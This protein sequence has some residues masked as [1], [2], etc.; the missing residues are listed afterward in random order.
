MEGAESLI[1]IGIF[2]AVVV[3]IA[4]ICGI[5]DADRVWDSS[6]EDSWDYID[7]INYQE[8]SNVELVGD[9]DFV[10]FTLLPIEVGEIRYYRLLLEKEYRGL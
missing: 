7:R 8:L 4:S 3:G 10:G 1:I 6:G 9:I 2:I 5:F